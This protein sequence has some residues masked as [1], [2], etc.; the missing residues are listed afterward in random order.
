MEPHFGVGVTQQKAPP[1]ARR[2]PSK[3]AGLVLTPVEST[4]DLA[5]VYACH[6]TKKAPP[7][8]A[9]GASSAHRESR[10]RLFPSR[11]E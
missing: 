1:N 11:K 2:L 10:M 3:G 7:A 8:A 6:G 4:A 9:S 5:P